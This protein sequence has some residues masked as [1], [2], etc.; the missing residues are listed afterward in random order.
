M[1]EVALAKS[2]PVRQDRSRFSEGHILQKNHKI[3]VVTPAGRRHYLDLLKHYVL[4]DEFVD[5]WHLWDNCRDPLDRDYINQLASENAK[6][7]V[8]VDGA[9]AAKINRFYSKC[10]DPLSFYIKID[11]DV[12][13]VR[14]GTFREMYRRAVAEP[15]RYLWW[16]PVVINNALSSYLLQTM[17]ALATNYEL[18]AQ[19]SGFYGWRDPHFAEFLHRAFV[20]HVR[21][22]AKP[23]DLPDRDV[24]LSRFSINCIGFFG[25][26]G[27]DFVPLHV[28]DEEWLS[29]TLP[30]IRGV[31]GCIVGTGTVAHFAFGIQEEHLLHT[32]LLSEYY[33]LAGI[34]QRFVHRPKRSLGSQ[35]RAARSQF[36]RAVRKR[37][38]RN[39]R[40]VPTV[41]FANSTDS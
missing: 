23:I 2:R 34:E 13:Y 16:S 11:D 9:A 8:V 6:I 40:F 32:D 36:G 14:S 24:F 1:C 10:D 17:K 35:Y 19:A 33:R 15:R 29:A 3:I 4:G 37:M 20:D 28:D 7:T 39:A 31:G 41:R 5:E 12:V 25:E 27:A 26:P 21:S 38:G 30:T 22:G 18:T